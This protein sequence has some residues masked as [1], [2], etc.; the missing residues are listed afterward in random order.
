MSDFSSEKQESKD[1]FR[2]QINELTLINMEINDILNESDEF[3]VDN[4]Q[5]ILAN[6]EATLKRGR[7]I[8]AEI[9]EISEKHKDTYGETE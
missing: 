9:K 5:K 6:L 1:V 3:I 4:L 8:C 7:I 2:K